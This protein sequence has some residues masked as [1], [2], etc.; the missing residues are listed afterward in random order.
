MI[1]KYQNIRKIASGQE[2]DYTT[3]CLLDYPY[4]KENYKM[5]AIRLSK[6][7]VLDSDPT[8]STDPNL[9]D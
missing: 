3:G 4:F 1:L 7:E 6:Q 8:D 5:I 2:D 9:T